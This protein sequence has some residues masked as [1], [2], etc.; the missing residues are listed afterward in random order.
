MTDEREVSIDVAIGM[1]IGAETAR[2]AGALEYI[3]NL[4]ALEPNLRTAIQLLNNAGLIV[5]KRA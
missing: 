4:L 1:A 5:V 3:P 2:A